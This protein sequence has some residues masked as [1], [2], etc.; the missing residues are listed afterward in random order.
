MHSYS[1][2]ILFQDSVPQSNMT[3]PY[4]ATRFMLLFQAFGELANVKQ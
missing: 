4:D 2:K 1:I 3:L